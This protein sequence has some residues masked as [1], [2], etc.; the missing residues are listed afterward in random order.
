MLH[1]STLISV[2]QELMV[3][4]TNNYFRYQVL[5]LSTLFIMHQTS[6]QYHI[7]KVLRYQILYLSTLII[8]YQE[9]IV[10]MNKQPIGY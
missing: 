10:A 4:Y 3:N 2:Y 6:G 8:M 7:H 5:N 9:E 1:V